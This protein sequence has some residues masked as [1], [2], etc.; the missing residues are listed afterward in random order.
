MIVSFFTVH[1]INFFF[2]FKNFNFKMMLIESIDT[3]DISFLFFHVSLLYKQKRKIQLINLMY[4][5]TYFLGYPL[6]IKKH[7]FKKY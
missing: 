7:I 2:K 5:L 3:W 6:L 1:E 4:L